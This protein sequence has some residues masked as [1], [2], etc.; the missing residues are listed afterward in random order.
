M[1]GYLHGSHRIMGLILCQPPQFR[2][3][4]QSRVKRAA[5]SLADSLAA[6]FADSGGRVRTQSDCVGDQQ[7]VNAR[8]CDSVPFLV[9]FLCS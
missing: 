4:P 2:S 7:C 5:D 9:P 1:E 3:R 6:R 8:R